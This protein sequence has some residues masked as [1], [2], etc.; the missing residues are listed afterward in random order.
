MEK[1]LIDR[2]NRWLLLAI[3]L[4]IISIIRYFYKLSAFPCF[5]D[6]EF[7]TIAVAYGYLKTGTLYT[8]DFMNDCISQNN[9]SRA[10]P[11]TILLANWLRIFGLSEVAG[12]SLS[13]I[14]GII[15][16]WSCIYV[17][18][19]LF[20][21]I[22]ITMCTCFIVLANTTA[23][24]YFRF[25]R[26]YALLIPICV[27]LIYF[28]YKALT[29]KN[30]I[31]EQTSDKFE[32]NIKY[33]VLSLLFL[34]FAWQIHVNSLIIVLG[35]FPYIVYKLITDKTKKYKL[36]FGLVCLLGGIIVLGLFFEKYAVKVPVIGKIIGSL[37]RHGSIFTNRHT[38]YF[39]FIVDEFGSALLAILFFMTSMIF[40]LND[41]RKK[42]F[43][44][45]TDLTI[46]CSSIILTG[47]FFLVFVAN[48]YYAPQ[49]IVMLVT[50]SAVI[51][52]VGYSILCEI[53]TAV[54]VVINLFLL[55][56]ITF[57]IVM[58]YKSIYTMADTSDYINA[59]K[60][61]SLY[62][63]I[64]NDKFPV[65]HLNARSYYYSQVWKKPI[66]QSFNK[67][68]DMEILLA[69]VQKYN[70]GILTCE[71][72]KLG[73]LTQ[74]VGDLLLNWSDRISGE[75][76]D[77]YNV[78]ISHYNF[79]SGNY[80]FTKTVTDKAIQLEN[81]DGRY[82][83]I[84]NLGKIPKNTQIVLVELIKTLESGREIKKY[85]QLL[86]ESDISNG[87]FEYLIEEDI[88]EDTNIFNISLGNE[89]AVYVNKAN[90][91]LTLDV[92]TS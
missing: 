19:K 23:T 7:Q 6:D 3:G 67:E 56:A 54:K 14:L 62:Y 83:I 42:R 28:L 47:V 74:G 30:Y 26:M 32:F 91:L 65:A 40:V 58:G 86:I 60:K 1:T 4:T 21:R 75:G 8:W 11:Y 73:N 34:F 37:V 63:D 39:I 52:A 24:Y 57:S 44:Q 49:Y 61:V 69:F 71:K 79:L 33:V 43:S 25:V 17:T 77:N 66:L 55:L 9:Y 29:E 12:R 76:I 82:R 46:Y 10:W 27:W 87:Y 88:L 38:E 35:I 89:Y 51:Y 59:Y 84:V 45:Y 70:K 16:I 15:T 92:D 72:A 18:K 22:G 20:N 2:N 50:I 80:I 41:I 31:D 64:D 85:Y 13:A 48:R 68:N 90:N 81:N 36:L 78:E 53:H 5:F